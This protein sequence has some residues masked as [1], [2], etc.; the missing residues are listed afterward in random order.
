M[1]RADDH[2]FQYVEGQ[3]RAGCATLLAQYQQDSDAVA[4]QAHAALD[5]PYGPHPRQVFDF[6]AAAVRT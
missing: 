1:Q 4:R 6:F 2:Q 3:G 5:R